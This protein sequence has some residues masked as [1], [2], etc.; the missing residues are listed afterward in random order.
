MAAVGGCGYAGIVIC[1]QRPGTASGVVF[2]TLEDETGF[3]NLVLWPDVFEKFGVIG[4]TT[5]FLGVTG[6]V[7]EIGLFTTTFDTPDNRRIFVP[8]SLIFGGTIENVTHHQTRRV[9]VAVGTD[10]S[11]DLD[12]T[13]A[14]YEAGARVR[15]EVLPFI[16]DIAGAFEWA[17]LVVCRV[18]DG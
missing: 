7:Q 15:A 13:R 10:Y 5:S 11:A 16:A 17:D 12:A 18:G 8:N 2:M 1:R 14:R 6:K 9:D 4:R 3:V